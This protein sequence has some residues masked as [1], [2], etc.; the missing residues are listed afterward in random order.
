MA[1][2]DQ[3][4]GMSHPVS[5][6]PRR[7]LGTCLV[8]NRHFRAAEEVL[9]AGYGLAVDA[10]EYAPRMRTELAGALAELYEAWGKSEIAARYRAEGSGQSVGRHQ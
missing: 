10:G 8:R 4:W 1:I 3:G 9:L 7:L 2:A 6:R 5:L